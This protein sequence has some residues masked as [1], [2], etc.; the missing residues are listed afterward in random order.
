[1]PA[2]FIHTRL[3]AVALFVAVGAAAPAQAQVTSTS[4]TAPADPRYALYDADA[5]QPA[6]I[7]VAGTAAGSGNVDVL[8][9]SRHAYGPDIR[10]VARNVPVAANGT[11][12]VANAPL[13]EVASVDSPF[14]PGKTCRLHA[15]PAGTTPEN[16][17]AFTGPRLAVSKFAR[18]RVPSDADD[19]PVYDSYVSAA[20]LR[21]S[22]DALSFGSYGLYD[23]WIL[24]PDTSRRRATGSM[25]TARCSTTPR[26]RSTASRSMARGRTPRPP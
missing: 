15:V 12:S 14:S 1:M 2:S 13:D 23:N 21:F 8:C 5:A 3:W 7:D 20:G 22:A 16:L 18:L 4:I 24:D 9:A 17:G 26:L 25:A 6:T 19:Q 10:S 11:F